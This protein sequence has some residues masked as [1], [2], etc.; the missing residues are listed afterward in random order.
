AS[1]A[2]GAANLKSIEFTGSGHTYTHG[3]ALQRFGPLPRFDLKSMTFTADYMTPGS[4]VETVRVQGDNPPRGGSPQPIV[5]ENR[6]TTCL[7][8]DCGGGC[9]AGGGGRG[10]GPAGPQGQDADVVEQRQIQ[11][12][13][14]PHGFLVAAAKSG[15][16]RVAEK[17]IGGKRF[18]VVSFPR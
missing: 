7:R 16:A 3:Q 8:G 11:L 2:M 18:R 17:T 15:A 5:G 4:R 6:G 9:S 10:S 12:W 1:T 13:G 14:T